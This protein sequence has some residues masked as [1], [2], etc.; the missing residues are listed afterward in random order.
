MTHEHGKRYPVS[1]PPLERQAN[2][3]RA[4]LGAYRKGFS[5]SIGGKKESDCPYKDYRKGNGRHET[6]VLNALRSDVSSGPSSR[7][8]RSLDIHITRGT[9]NVTTRRWIRVCW[10]DRRR[11]TQSPVSPTKPA[12]AGRA[13]T[14]FGQDLEQMK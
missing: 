12:C 3:N 11:V 4:H 2:W 7:L 5:A 1:D 8:H 13:K 9:R 10:H 14:A 6:G